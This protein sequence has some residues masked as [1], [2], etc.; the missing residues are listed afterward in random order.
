MGDL[1]RK[2]FGNSY[3]VQYSGLEG[4]WEVGES[5]KAKALTKLC[6]KLGIPAEQVPALTTWTWPR[7]RGAG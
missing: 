5:D 7:E 4:L 3:C 1:V 6:Q 2:C